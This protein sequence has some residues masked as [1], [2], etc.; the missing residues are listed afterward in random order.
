MNFPKGFTLIEL[1]IVMAIVS[2]LMGLVGPL[3]ISS[4][5]KAR[6]KEELLSVKHW[7]SRIS[8]EAYYSGQEKCLIFQGKEVLVTRCKEGESSAKS[9]T[10]EYLFFQPQTLQFNTNGFAF[11]NELI[12]DYRGKSATYL[13]DRLLENKVTPDTPVIIFNGQE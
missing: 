10:F 1:M 12:A 13:L 5:E 4:V 8:A 2:L 6:T 7:L 11:P 9:I 3:A